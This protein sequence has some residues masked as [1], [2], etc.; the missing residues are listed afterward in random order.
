LIANLSIDQDDFDAIPVLAAAG[1]WKPADRAFEGRL[2]RLLKTLNQAI[3][4]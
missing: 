3:A 1:G 2:E 4:T